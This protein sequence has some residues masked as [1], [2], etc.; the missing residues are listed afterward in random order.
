MKKSSIAFIPASTAPA[1]Q[2]T[3]AD[4]ISSVEYLDGKKEKTKALT[5]AG[6]AIVHLFV[7]LLFIIIDIF[8]HLFMYLLILSMKIVSM[9]MF[10]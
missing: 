6:K 10:L 8:I 4:T 2:G 1:P 3:P 7:V 5:R 9:M